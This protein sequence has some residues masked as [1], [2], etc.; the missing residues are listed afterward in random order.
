MSL[1]SGLCVAALLCALAPSAARAQMLLSS[2]QFNQQADARVFDPDGTLGP[3]CQD[4]RRPTFPIPPDTSLP[5]SFA[6]TAACDASGVFRV[7]TTASV[8]Y[9]SDVDAVGNV[10]SVS[11]TA[12]LTGETNAPEPTPPTGGTNGQARATGRFGFRAPRSTVGF[13][14]S[15]AMGPG[16]EFLD[17]ITV[18]VGAR[19]STG[20][21][22]PRTGTW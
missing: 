3:P 21:S 11:F 4:L 1:A 7:S 5:T 9:R 6:D 15:V 10:T 2:V 22:P 17:G 13:H 19:A 16:A 18:T 14:I 12:R 8:D 20:P